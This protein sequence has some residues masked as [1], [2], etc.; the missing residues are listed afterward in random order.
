MDAKK[1]QGRYGRIFKQIE[2]LMIKSSDPSA[3]MCTISSI[4]HHKM[5][6]FFWTGFYLLTD[7]GRL[8]VRSYQGPVACMELAKNTGVCWNGINE[9]KTIIVED[10]SKFPNHITCDSRSK[11]E[12]VVPVKNNTGNIV[13]ALDIDSDKLDTF[14]EVDAEELEKIIA[15]IYS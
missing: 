14:D 12:I 1:K 8:V 15:L 6:D 11:S 13:G 4:L 2:A 10:V 5:P 3:R 7:D 9:Q